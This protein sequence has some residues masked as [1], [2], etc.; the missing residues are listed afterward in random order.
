MDRF[1]YPLRLQFPL[2][3]NQLAETRDPAAPIEAIEANNVLDGL[4]LVEHLHTPSN[5]EYPF[6]L[7][8]PPASQ[9]EREALELEADRLVAAHD[10]LADLALA[11]AVHQAV[12]GNYDRVAATLDAYAKGTFPPEPEVVRTP[13]TGLTLTHRV[14]I[15]FEAGLDPD[16]S[17]LLGIPISP[18]SRAQPMMNSWLA[19]L[20]PPPDEIGCRVEWLD[21]A[22]RTARAETVTQA[23]LQLQPID[24]LTIGTLDGEA[25]MGELDDRIVRHVI[26]KRQPRADAVLSVRHTLRLQAPMKTFFELAP[27]LRHLRSL[28]FASR[29]LA[30]TDI[31]LSGE[32]D[33]LQGGTQTIARERVQLVQDELEALA[34]DLSGFD[35]ETSAVDAVIDAAVALLARAAR[36]GRQQVGW[37]FIYEW[38]RRTFAALLARVEDV[39]DRWTQRLAD[40]D[41]GF[42][43]YTAASAGMSINE[44][45]AALAR[46]DLFL[47]AMPLSPRPSTPAVYETALVGPSAP[48]SRR[49]VLADR[50]AELETILTTNDPELGA[51]VSDIVALGS[52]SDLDHRPL[53]IDDVQA[54]IVRFRAELNARLRNLQDDL[55]QRVARSKDELLTHDASADTVV[56][57]ESLQRAAAAL[58]GDDVKLI[59][60]FTFGAA[61]RDELANAYAARGSLTDYLV[62]AHKVDFPVED[63]LHG[64]AR[65]R[66]KL[67]AWEQAG[68]LSDVLGGGDPTLTPIQLPFRAGEGWLAAEFDPALSIDGERLL[69]TA[70]YAV[71][72]NPAGATCGLLV[73][74]WTEVIPG[75]DETAGLAFHYDRP[76]SEPPQTWLLVTPPRMAGSWEWSDLLGAIDETFALLRIRAVEPADIESRPY[77]QFLPATTSAATLYGVS[78]ATNYSRVND[79]AAQLEAAADG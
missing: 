8:L 49:E 24:L 12:L 65:V 27:L 78:I 68:L 4:K 51:L 45:L 72:P 52:L 44:R 2:V 30:P 50:K 42:A 67:F 36:T 55:E 59:P 26:E 9:A 21:P 23:A 74:E 25:A 69:Y 76:S 53:S 20:L 46:L 16:V 54:D 41:A 32:A 35:A 17:P 7:R 56:R 57:V 75:K 10:A 33:T 77:A 43:T 47:A 61:Q 58:L 11:E 60:E 39:A 62:T 64:V 63:W 70:H 5:R 18:R 37:G 71:A 66:D 19:A 38:R 73:D 79:L 48:P 13:R 40:F 29:P 3:A 34:Q 31:A 28:L 15:H 22:T 6:G 1:I 14:A